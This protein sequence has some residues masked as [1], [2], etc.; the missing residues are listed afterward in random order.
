MDNIIISEKKL[1]IIHN[2]MKSILKIKHRAIIDDI[3]YSPYYKFSKKE[4][5]DLTKMIENLILDYL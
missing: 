4:N 2:Y 5:I 3:F 1:N